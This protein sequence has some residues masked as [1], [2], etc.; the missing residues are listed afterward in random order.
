MFSSRF[1]IFIPLPALLACHPASPCHLILDVFT[2][3]PTLPT[4]QYLSILAEACPCVLRLVSVGEEVPPTLAEVCDVLPQIVPYC[5]GAIMLFPFT[6]I[7][8]KS[9]VPTLASSP[10]S[11]NHGSVRKAS[12]HHLRKSE[13]FSIFSLLSFSHFSFSN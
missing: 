3:W 8:V 1:L 6:S 13:S 12:S 2:L 4:L 7:S 10:S 5:S 11:A 9:S